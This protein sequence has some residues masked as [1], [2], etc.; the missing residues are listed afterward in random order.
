MF[1]DSH[2]HLDRVDLDDFNN[3]FAQLLSTIEQAGVTRMLCIGVNLES[4]DAMHQRIEP[5]QH[6]YCSAGVHP[7]YADVQEPTVEQLCALATRDRVVAI[8]ETGL[9]YFHQSGDLDWQRKRFTTHIEAARECALPLIIHTREAREDTLKLLRKHQAQT[10]GGVLHCFTEDWEMARAAI[11]LG[12]Y[13]SISGI[14][15]FHQAQNVRD[16]AQQIPLER[17]LIETDAPWLSPAPYR[18]KINHPGRVKLVAE[19][20]AEIRGESLATLARATFDNANR[21]F[22]LN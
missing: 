20:L 1:F 12:F 3:D 16:M 13:I 7:D 18:G 14:V 2:C 10:V 19:K 11:D 6:I 5:Y 17:L 9:D 22:G 8:G 21:L 4:F 15:T